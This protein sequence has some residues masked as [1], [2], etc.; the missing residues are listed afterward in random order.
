MTSQQFIKDLEAVK[1]AIVAELPE[2]VERMGFDLAAIVK[3]RVVEKGKTA[4][5]DSFTPY[6]SKQLP[7]WFFKGR[8][9]NNSGESAVTALA[10]QGER[11]SYKDFRRVNGLQSGVKNFEFTGEMWRGVAVE[12][13]EGGTAATFTIRGGTATSEDRLKWHSDREDT[14]LLAPSPEEITLASRAL[15]KWLTVKVTAL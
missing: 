9:R 4:E 7:A 11:M 6:S 3:K 10:K 12:V 5:G 13:A 8:S 15:I 1:R 2:Q 14:N